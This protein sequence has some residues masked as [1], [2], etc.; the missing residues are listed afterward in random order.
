MEPRLQ[1]RVQ[2]YGWDIAA[3]SYESLWQ[4]QIAHAQ[5][6]M[7]ARAR[8]E[9]GDRVLDVA[10]GTGLVAFAAAEA[11][12]PEGRVVGVDLSGEMVDVARNRA[13]EQDVRNASFARMDAESLDLPDAS[14]DVAFCALGLMYIPSPRRAVHEI[15]RV[16]RPGGRIGFAV[17]GLRSACGWSA[18]FPIVDAEVAT[19][20]CPLFFELGEEDR[21]ARLCADVQLENVVAHRIGTTLDYADADEA[22]SAAFVGG[23]VALA[24]SRF[25]DAVRARVRMRYLEAIRPWQTGRGYRIPGEFVV[26]AAVAT[27]AATAE[28]PRPLAPARIAGR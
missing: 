1:R 28:S 27:S 24:W 16:V 6:E 19:E 22:C 21:L 10:C 9:R 25:D 23:P 20:V 5:S 26:V 15:R 2:R 8:L 4:A 11:V 12:G 18:V 13:V 3:A 14:F 17:W 7:I